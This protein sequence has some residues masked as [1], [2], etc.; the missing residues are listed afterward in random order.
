MVFYLI[1][2]NI[3]VLFVAS[4]PPGWGWWADPDDCTYSFCILS[5]KLITIYNIVFMIFIVNLKGKVC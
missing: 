5:E 3:V 2:K 4:A 1:D